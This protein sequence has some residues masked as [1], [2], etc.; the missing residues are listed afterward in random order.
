MLP[1]IEYRAD[2]RIKIIEYEDHDRLQEDC[3]EVLSNRDWW[4]AGCS[5]VPHNPEEVCI[6]RIMAGNERAKQHEL[7]HCHGYADTMLPWKADFHFHDR[8]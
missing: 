3:A 1:G 2:P 4:Y 5:L 7:A 8:Q 6:I